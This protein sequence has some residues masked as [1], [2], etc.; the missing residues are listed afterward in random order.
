MPIGTTPLDGPSLVDGVWVK[1]VAAGEN[2]SYVSGI[3]AAG[4]TQAGAKQLLAGNTLIEIDTAE[5][6][7][8]VALPVAIPGIEISIYNAG[9]NTVTVYPSIANNGATGAQDTIGGT[10]SAT[11]AA[12][13]SGYFFCAKVGSWASK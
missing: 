10:T 5:S 2:E 9:A 11:I 1:A 12:A 3:T 7:T 4:S 8:G 6:G 13:A